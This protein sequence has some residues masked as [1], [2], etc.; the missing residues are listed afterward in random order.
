MLVWRSVEPAVGIIVGSF[1]AWLTRAQWIVCR[2]D[3]WHL[4][5][6]VFRRL[7]AHSGLDAAVG[8]LLL[9]TAS[10]DAFFDHVHRASGLRRTCESVCAA[11]SMVYT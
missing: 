1:D 4:R 9:S 7:L 5:T 2:M 11:P 8:G 10:L 3:E 6:D